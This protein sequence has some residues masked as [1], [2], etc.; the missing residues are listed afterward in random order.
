MRHYQPKMPEAYFDAHVPVD[1]FGYSKY[2]CARHVESL[3]DAVELRLFG[4]FGK[5]EDW[6]IR[7]ISNAISKTLFDLPIT[8]NQ[9]RRFDYVSVDDVTPVVKH[10]IENRP[11]QRAYN[12]TPDG[13]IELKSIAEKVRDISGKC[14][15]IRIGQPGMGI[16]YSGDNWVLRQDLPDWHLTP[17]DDAISKLYSWYLKNTHA[18]SKD[19]LLVDK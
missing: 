9:N 14:V 17:I 3:E 16:E 1:E 15:D 19:A 11:R 4:V 6:S 18:I 5:Y 13:G 2:V 12:V 8:I 7:F 10:F